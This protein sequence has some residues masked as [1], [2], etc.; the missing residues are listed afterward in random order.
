MPLRGGFPGQ[1]QRPQTRIVRRQFDNGDSSLRNGEGLGQKRGEIKPP[2][3]EPVLFSLQ[4]GEVGPLVDLGFGF[5]VVKAVERDVAGPEPFDDKL[6]VKIRDRLKN[7]IAEREFK[8]IVD[9]LKRKATVV[10][11]QN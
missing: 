9:E 2:Q 8:R 7:V 5:H 3:A 4:A 1:A 10:V 6:Q 11:Y